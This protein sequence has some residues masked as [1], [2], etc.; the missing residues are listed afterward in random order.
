MNFGGA[1][2]LQ[3]GHIPKD[4]RT[5]PPDAAHP[6]PML[7]FEDI[8]ILFARRFLVPVAASS[9]VVGGALFLVAALLM[10]VAYSDY[11]LFFFL[12]LVPG[13]L[14]A[15][16]LAFVGIPAGYLVARLRRGY[17]ESLWLLVGIGAAA[18][19]IL[20]F[21]P[22]FMFGGPADVFASLVF[23]GAGAVVA[24][25]WTLLNRDLFRRDDDA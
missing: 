16:G 8:L 7:T 13:A 21:I 1:A 9:L 10:G 4:H 11:G 23:A 17:G 25:L 2:A 19:L 14:S 5:M 24:G 20:S 12:F 18:G 3:A 22:S 6:N 15:V